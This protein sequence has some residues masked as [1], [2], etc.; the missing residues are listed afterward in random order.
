M[1]KMVLITWVDSGGVDGKVWDFKDDY[2]IHVLECQTIGFVVEETKQHMVVAQSQNPDQW[3]RL[4]I[5]PR[6]CITATQALSTDKKLPEP[7]TPAATPSSD[8]TREKLGELL[9]DFTAAVDFNRDEYESGG[10]DN[11]QMVEKIAIKAIESLLNEARREELQEIR[12]THDAT[13]GML[14]PE[15]P[16]D[17][18]Q[19]VSLIEDRISE[20]NQENN[21]S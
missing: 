10:E 8:I 18:C 11:Y 5:I 15:V 2:D 20:L 9:R 13:C 17:D 21:E 16:R 19:Y 4:F 3:G 7:T 14:R 6:G 1:S 12:K